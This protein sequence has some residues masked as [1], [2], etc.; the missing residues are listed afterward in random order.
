[1]TRLTE[2]PEI[3]LFGRTRY[4]EGWKRG[5]KKATA[6]RRKRLARKEKFLQRQFGEFYDYLDD[7]IFK[8]KRK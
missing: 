6:D 4:K 8:N 2:K 1:M 7:M 5:Y 3:I